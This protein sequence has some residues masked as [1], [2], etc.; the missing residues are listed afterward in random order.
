MFMI[1]VRRAGRAQICKSTREIWNALSSHKWQLFESAE[2]V[3]ILGK[4]VLAAG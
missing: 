1:V 4:P 2:L 3:G